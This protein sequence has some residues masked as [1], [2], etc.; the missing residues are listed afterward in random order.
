LYFG[1]RQTDR[2]TDRQ[3]NRWTG[4]LHEAALAVASGGLIKWDLVLDTHVSNRLIYDADGLSQLQAND[5][6]MI[7]F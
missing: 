5:L 1:D 7:I 6:I 3:K 4:P 2:Q